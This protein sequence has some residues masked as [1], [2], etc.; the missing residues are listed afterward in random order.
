M[1]LY[2]FT[3][4]VELGLMY[5]QLTLQK[6][7][8][9]QIN[10]SSKLDG[11]TTRGC[12]LYSVQRTVRYIQTVLQLRT[13]NQGYAVPSKLFIPLKFHSAQAVPRAALSICFGFIRLYF[14]FR[15]LFV[16]P[17]IKFRPI[18]R[19]K[20]DTPFFTKNIPKLV[21]L[22]STLFFNFRMFKFSS[23]TILVSVPH[24]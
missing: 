13:D 22:A 2:I 18:Y 5:L 6:H 10:N 4:E 8:R 11:I 15:E 1:Y 23:F 21:L 16:Q 9:S 12:S 3:P 17:L 19:L 20:V 14:V 24:L 7:S